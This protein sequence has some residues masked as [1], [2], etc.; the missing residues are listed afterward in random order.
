MEL[1]G[2]CEHC[3]SVENNLKLR[4]ELI[5]LQSIMSGNITSKKVTGNSYPTN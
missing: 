3:G 5:N 2:P 1:K 4:V